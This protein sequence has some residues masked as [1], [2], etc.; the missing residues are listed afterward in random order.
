MATIPHTS[1]ISSPLPHHAL[2]AVIDSLHPQGFNRNSMIEENYSFSD[3]RGR[4]V[5]TNALA[6]THELYRT[7]DYTGITLFN[8]S[9]NGLSEEDLVKTLAQTAA[10]FHLVHNADSQTYNFWVTNFESNTDQTLPNIKRFV[11]EINY[12]QVDKVVREYA[13]D[14]SPKKIINVKQ[15]RDTFKYFDKAIGY[16]LSLWAIE[17]TGKQLVEKFGRAVAN[18]RSQNLANRLVTDISIQTLA[19]IILAHT[20]ALGSRAREDESQLNDI[21]LEAQRRFPRYFKSKHLEKFESEIS[22]TYRILSELRYAGFA[23]EMLTD[24]YR[25]AFPDVKDKRELG[26]YD[27]PLYLTRRIWENIPVEYLRPGHRLSADMTCGWGSFL[28]AA[29]ERLSRLSDMKGENLRNHIFG[30]DKDEF[31]SRLAGL[32]L[33]TATRQDSW[34]IDHDDALAWNLKPK[35]PNIIVGNP[36]FGGNRKTISEREHASRVEKANDF[37]KHAID[38]LADEGYLAMLMPQSFVASEA[39]PSVR[40]HLLTNCDVFEI[41]ELPIGI[42]EA[43]ASSIVIFAQKRTKGMS[44]PS[45]IRNIQQNHIDDFRINGKFSTSCIVSNQARWNE[46]SKRSKNNNYVIDYKLLLPE[47]SWNKIISTSFRLDDMA[48]IFQGLIEG[49]KPESKRMLDH[50]DSTEIQ[51]YKGVRN[52]IKSPYHTTYENPLHAVYPNDFEEPRYSYHRYF[53]QE[54]VLLNALAN[55]SRWEK[56][57]KVTIDRRGVYVSDNFVIVALHDAPALTYVSHEVVAAVMDWKVC[58]AWLVEHLK[59]PRFPLSAIRSLPFPKLTEDDCATIKSAVL[60]IE[61]AKQRGETATDHFERIID[62][63]LRYAYKL[64]DT[65]YQLLSNIIGQEEKNFGSSCTYEK[66]AEWWNVCGAVEAVDATNSEVTL[67]MR[68]FDALQTIQIP[69][70]MPG[71]VL[72]EGATFCTKIPRELLKKGQLENNQLWGRF[73][74]QEYTYMDEAELLHSLNEIA[75]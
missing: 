44:C 27:T 41:W 17:V 66:I 45:R 40:K 37:L 63:T 74:P 23:P 57:V 38:I 49:Q 18:L 39:S 30:N 26:R 59:H 69:P 29:H 28:I 32:S 4:L 67:W 7:P 71:W 19:A 61:A 13:V 11:S 2:N 47:H 8:F 68:G 6:F 46:S 36:P 43:T 34:Q 70:E 25:E 56:K 15:G 1:L 20:G 75:R 52:V 55:N 21:L 65:S 64:D 31:T 53:S 42:F 10:P 48:V 51:W 58:N 5:K 73:Y 35:R 9:P 16:Q 24:L 50:V 72:R 12:S 60:E 62:E 3:Q 14:L 54:K 33:L 22:E